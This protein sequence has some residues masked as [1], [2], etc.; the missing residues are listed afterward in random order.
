[1]A[2]RNHKYWKH[3]SLSKR[4][5]CRFFYEWQIIK[6][7][8]MP[9]QTKIVRVPTSSTLQ[10]SL[11]RLYLRVMVVPQESWCHIYLQYFTEFVRAFLSNLKEK[12]FSWSFFGA[13]SR[14]NES[15]WYIDS[16]TQS[17]IFLDPR[18]L[19]VHVHAILKHL[20]NPVYK[21]TNTGYIGI[22]YV[23]DS[24]KIL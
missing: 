11:T 9:F 18:N 12:R 17:M 16:C 22:R 20:S 21:T 5:K 15:M 2:F 8:R 24:L 19:W 6:L 1:M 3:F 10:K 14:S 4:S 13:L 7:T 23:K